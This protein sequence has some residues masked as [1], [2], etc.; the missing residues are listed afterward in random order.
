MELPFISAKM[1]TYGRVSTLEEALHS[2]LIQDYPKDKC[3]LIIVN[4]YPLQKLVFDHPQ[5]YIYNLD[6]TFETIGEKE[7]Y[8]IRK[9]QGPLIAVWDDDDIA[10]S[11]HLQNIAK[12]WKED[13]NLL[14]WLKGVA[15][16]DKKISAIGNVGNSGIVYSKAAWYT[17]GKSPIMNA[18]GDM[19]LV[20]ALQALDNSKVVRAFPPDDEV[21]WFYYWANRSFHQSGLGTD[22][23]TRPNII[24]RNSEHIENE[25]KK[26]NIPTGTIELKPHWDIDYQQQ[27]IK[28]N[29]K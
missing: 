18:G 14:H 6:E 16:N 28:F 1:I 3:E 29:K 21:S 12:Y 11:N 7:N 5:V 25:R 19:V 23:D 17:I 13:T 9:C 22:D 15:Y 10:M 24:V 20:Q 26:G 8:A 2:F 4:D 27:L